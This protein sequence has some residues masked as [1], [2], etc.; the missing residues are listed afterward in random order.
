MMGQKYASHTIL[1]GQG[2]ITAPSL[3][4]NYLVEL[5]YESGDKKSQHLIVI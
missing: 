4:G 1:D 3:S 2:E 5:I